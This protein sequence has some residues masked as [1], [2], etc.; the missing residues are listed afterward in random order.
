MSAGRISAASSTSAKKP[1]SMLSQWPS[2]FVQD[3][4]VVAVIIIT[5]MFPSELKSPVT[6]GLSDSLFMLPV[7]RTLEREGQNEVRSQMLRGTG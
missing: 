7:F 4:N 1:S 6:L 3:V 5:S 2:Q